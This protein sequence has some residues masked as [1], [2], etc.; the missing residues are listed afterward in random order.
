MQHI[1]YCHTRPCGKDLWDRAREALFSSGSSQPP[2]QPPSHPATQSPSRPYRFDFMFRTNPNYL[3][4]T[5][6]VRDPNFCSGP[7]FFLGPIFFSEAIFFRTHNFFGTQL[8]SFSED[9]IFWNPIFFP[10]QHFIFGDPDLFP[11]PA[12]PNPNPTPT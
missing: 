7:K 1:N 10:D 5:I 3:S 11:T 12:Q 6:F 4:N 9:N 8:K 2:S